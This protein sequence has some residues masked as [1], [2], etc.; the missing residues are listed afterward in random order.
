MTPT[1]VSVPLP[2]DAGLPNLNELHTNCGAHNT[3]QTMFIIVLGPQVSFFFF[4]L[5]SLCLFYKLTTVL[6]NF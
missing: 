2:A 5:S 3:T 1:N 6:F 4:S